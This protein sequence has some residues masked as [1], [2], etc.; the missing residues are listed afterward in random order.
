MNREQ[1]WTDD[2]RQAYAHT[3]QAAR[4]LLVDLM[5]TSSLEQRQRLLKKIDSVRQDFA[6]LKCLQNARQDPP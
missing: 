4:Q 2:Y 6:Q 3:E 1:L 5:A